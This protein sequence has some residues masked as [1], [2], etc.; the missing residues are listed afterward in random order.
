M[1]KLD[2]VLKVAKAFV[3]SGVKLGGQLYIAEKVKS[4]LTKVEDTVRGK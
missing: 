1:E 2:L 3:V 4:V